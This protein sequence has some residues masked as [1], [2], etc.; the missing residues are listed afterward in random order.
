MSWIESDAEGLLLRVR[1][2]PRARKDAVCGVHDDALKIRLSA[3]P[4]DGKANRRLIR[5]LSDQCGA[6]PSQFEIVAGLRGR[7]KTVR[8]RGVKPQLVR[9]LLGD[10]A[11]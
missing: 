2:V 3:P 9:S 11:D 10:E 5:F 4:V 8:V 6:A 7:T 1:V